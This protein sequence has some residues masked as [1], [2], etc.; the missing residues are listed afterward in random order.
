MDLCESDDSPFY[1]VDHSIDDINYRIFSYRL[2]SRGDFSTKASYESRGIMFN[3]SDGPKLVCRPMEKFFN[4]HELTSEEADL[5]KTIMIL[6]KADGS[7]ISSYMS[8][9]KIRL[10]SKT[11]LS[12][13]QANDAMEWLYANPD[14]TEKVKHI[15][16]LGYTCNFEWV[17]PTNRIVLSYKEPHLILLNIRNNETGKY[18]SRDHELTLLLKDYLIETVDVGDSPEEFI[19]SV[20]S[21]ED[22]EGFVYVL[23]DKM[24]KIKCGWYINLHSVIS[25]ISSPRNLYELIIREQLDDVLPIIESNE[26]I[27]NVVLNEHKRLMCILKATLSEIDSFYNENKHLDRKSFAIKANANVTRPKF[28]VLMSM[29]SGKK[30]DYTEFMLKNYD[31][32]KP[33]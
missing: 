2:A 33:E 4:L 15:T 23:P 29:Y 8:G 20:H 22:V 13:D 27:L 19:K 6:P 32:F 21:M 12:S 25:N 1:Y 7:L 30:I 9:D 26:D 10:K 14:L 18:L 11:S 24:I 17:S 5:S 16:N 31:Y 28:S 3:L